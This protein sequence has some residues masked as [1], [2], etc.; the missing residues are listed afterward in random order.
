MK[1]RLIKFLKSQNISYS[2][3]ADEI[4][5]QRSSISHII[6]GRNN[7][8][9]ELIQKILSKYENLN[10]DWLILGKGDMYKVN[11]EISLFDNLYSSPNLKTNNINLENEKIKM[12][13]PINSEV[14]IDNQRHLIKKIILIYNDNTFEELNNSK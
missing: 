14:N 1:D 13:S 3:F 11:N 8:S 6:S 9:L 10:S 2:K 7:P 4:K 12:T 5:V